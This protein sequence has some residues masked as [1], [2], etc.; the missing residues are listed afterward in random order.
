VITVERQGS[1]F[2]FRVKPFEPMHGVGTNA[3]LSGQFTEHHLQF[4]SHASAST[5]LRHFAG[6]PFAVHSFQSLLVRL[7]FEHGF[8]GVAELWVDR[9]ALQIVNGRVAV[10]ALVTLA[11]AGE[12]TQGRQSQAQTTP[13]PRRKENS[14]P[15][16]E[17]PE[18]A[19]FVDPDEEAQVQ[20]LVQAAQSGAPFCEACARAA[21]AKNQ[22][23][24]A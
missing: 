2:H 1:H 21:A 23:N 8:H 16:V 20:T 14:S 15:P 18:A 13:P 5:F 6:N 12:S 11:P 9:L 22:S 17:Q 3:T 10:I 19:T 7:G 4:N 24:N